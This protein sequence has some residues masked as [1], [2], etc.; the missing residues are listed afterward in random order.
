MELSKFN[1]VLLYSNKNVEKLARKLINES[2]NAVL[3]EMFDDKC[4]LADHTTGQIF[5]AEYDF[6]GKIMTFSNFSEISLESHNDAI[7]E[8]IGDFFDDVNVNL[9]EAYE[10]NC[11]TASELFESSLTEALASK[12]MENV[13]NYSELAGINEEMSELK[14]TNVFK[15]F[16]ERL[17]E[18]PTETIKMFNWKDT[19]KVSLLDED[20]EKIVNRSSIVKA[21]TLKTD[22]AFKKELVESANEALEGYSERLESL[23]RENVSMLALDKAAL[24]EVVGMAVIGNKNLMENR[25]KI[26]DMIN[27]VIE[28]DIDLSSK[29]N[30]LL[31]AEEESE[32]DDAPEASDKDIEAVK[33]ALEK[34]KE[35]A[36]D[37]KLVKK[38]E[39]LI[40]SL[41]DSE[42]AGETNISAV[43]ESIE[44]LSL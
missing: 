17:A 38:I 40:S 35:K 6:D 23:V 10:K 39:D 7:K 41:E 5:E 13:I 26:V 15:T 11:G 22:A 34:A 29:R 25:N 19:V 9:A 12:N 30:F 28:E 31:E 2:A 36:S 33:A 14:S 4:I 16:T 43:K 1:D 8:A 32:T 3:M 20:V 44:L 37:E 24:K 18:H 21:K 42:D 27:N